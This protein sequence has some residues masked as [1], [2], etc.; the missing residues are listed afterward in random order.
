MSGRR[1]VAVP[2]SGVPGILWNKDR[3]KWMVRH[4]VKGGERLSRPL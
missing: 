1:N 3:R 2:Q 4:K